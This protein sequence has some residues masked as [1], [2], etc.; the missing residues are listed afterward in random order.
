ML[1]FAILIFCRVG[2]CI[3]VMQGLSSPRVPMHIRLF[4]AIALSLALMPLLLDELQAA[5]PTLPGPAQLA[6]LMISEIVIGEQHDV[7]EY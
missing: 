7:W 4:I 1:V 3:M 5:V 2:A 6:V